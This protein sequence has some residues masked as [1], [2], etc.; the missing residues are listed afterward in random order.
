MARRTVPF[1][2]E[3]IKKL[4]NN[5]PVVYKIEKDGSPLYTGVAKRRRVQE[6]L[7]EHLPTGKD[8][9][10]GGAKVQVEQMASI[11]AALKKEHN[12]LVRAKPPRNKKT[13]L[14]SIEQ[15]QNRE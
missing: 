15:D 2:N 7:Q 1:N 3:G 4:P 10:R 14:F 9:I 12:I 8:P 13:S 6:R 5:K 11:E